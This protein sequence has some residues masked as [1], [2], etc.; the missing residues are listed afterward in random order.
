MKHIPR[1]HKK[2]PPPIQQVAT[3]KPALHVA[4]SS[5]KVFKKPKAS[6]V[7]SSFTWNF[8]YREID[9]DTSH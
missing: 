6:K 8:S 7:C 2:T 4:G 3:K 5:M 1:A 9:N